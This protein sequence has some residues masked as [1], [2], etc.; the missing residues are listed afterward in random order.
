MISDRALRQQA[1]KAGILTEW[2]DYQGKKHVVSVEPL[3][4]LLRIIGAAD[5]EKAGSAQVPL[6]TA[7]A[8]ERLSLPAG[9]DQARRAWLTVEGQKQPVR[10]DVSG[11]AA[12]APAIPGYHRL[13]IGEREVILAVAPAK[14][15]APPT[16]RDWG[17]SVQ[18]YSL[19]RPGDGGIGSYAALRD[20][21]RSAAETG[22]G[23]IAVSP[24]HAQFSAD[25]SRFSP[26]A[27]SSR[28]WLNA[29]HID[30]GEAAAGLGLVAPKLAPRLGTGRDAL[31]NWPESSRAKLK[32]LRSL[33]DKLQARGLL[34]G[35][36]PL[37]RSLA[38]FKRRGGKALTDHACFE[39]LH[40]HFYGHDR[41]LWHWQTWPPELRDA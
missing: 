32:A 3:R 9:L 8:G 33:F 17:L 4:A 40:A 27:P 25:L 10:L 38:N 18:L 14:R 6:I 31:I 23:A 15:P 37:A 19:Y 5:A 39:S 28:L 41:K 20:F 21:T 34:V 30:V 16:A 22:A 11:D 26:Y 36:G 1:R 12:L 7:R 35:G 29:L 2:D 13:A 24:I